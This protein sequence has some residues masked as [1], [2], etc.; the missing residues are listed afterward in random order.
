[1][2]PGIKPL[3]VGLNSFPITVTAQDGTTTTYTVNVT[4]DT[5]NPYLSN[6]SVNGEQLV[7]ATEN[8]IDFDKDT[9]EYNI[10]LPFTTDSASVVTTARKADDIVTLSDGLATNS[11][12]LNTTFSVTNI[13]VGTKSYSALVTS[14]DGKT[15]TYKLNI[16]R[17]SAADANARIASGLVKAYDA[18]GKTEFTGDDLKVSSDKEPLINQF[19][20]EFTNAIHEYTYK[21]PNKVRN[22]EFNIQ[23][24]SNT[25]G[26]AATVRVV[27][28]KNLQVGKNEVVIA[29][30][31]ADGVT[32][33]NFYVEVEREQMAYAVNLNSLTDAQKDLGY[34]AKTDG[35][36]KYEVSEGDKTDKYNHVLNVKLGSDTI[37]KL[38]EDDIKSLIST[39]KKDNLEVKVISDLND[40]ALSE[41][42]ISISDGSETQLVKVNLEKSGSGF[43]FDNWWIWIAVGITALILTGILI[44]VNRDKFGKIAKKRKEA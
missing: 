8:P 33:Q 41:V 38:T 2:T 25:K 6:L 12:G 26:N 7:D 21:V 36:K 22:L 37:K 31:A 20:D 34:E 1:M 40:E 17:R 9:L 4:R 3:N 23:P 35:M 24:E 16:T 27:G 11:T 18:S 13:P 5:E 44:Q 30:T 39:A 10:I 43:N 29:V 14:V 28:N 15:I 42:I 32:T 19:N